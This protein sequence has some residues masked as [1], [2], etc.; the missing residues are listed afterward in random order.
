MFI[1]I[2]TA[3]FEILGD[4]LIHHCMIL[5]W[6][7]IWCNLRECKATV[8]R[9]QVIVIIVGVPWAFVRGLHE[10][11]EVDLVQENS[12]LTD[13]QEIKWHQCY[14]LELS[15]TSWLSLSPPSVS[16]NRLYILITI[17]AFNPHDFQGLVG[18]GITHIL[19]PVCIPSM[20]MH[21]P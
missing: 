17:S 11:V 14:R 6:E 16:P 7:V 13:T 9:K 15:G 21:Q 18:Q 4:V 10:M 1:Q 20:S 2:W 19:A 3:V 12:L 5:R 8:L